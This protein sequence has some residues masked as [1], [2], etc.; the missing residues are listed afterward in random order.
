VPGFLGMA[1]IAYSVTAALLGAVFL[2]LA[3]QVYRMDASDRAMR[4]A[5]RLFT[6][7]LLYLFLLYVVLLA[8][9]VL[10]TAGPVAAS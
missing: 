1:S 5:R 6:F 3:W 10:R 8:E 9:A 7:S 4:P 2:M